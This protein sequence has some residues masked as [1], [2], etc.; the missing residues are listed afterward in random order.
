[1]PDTGTDPH[2]PVGTGELNFTFGYRLLSEFAALGLSHVVISPGSRSTPLTL[3]AAMLQQQG[4]LSAHIILDERSA[5]FFALGIGKSTG[6]PVALICTSGTAAANYFP[7]VIEARMTSTPLLVLSADRPFGLHGVL[8]PQTINQTNLYGDYAVLFRESEALIEADASGLK[9]AELART[10]FE[11]SRTEGGPAHLN[12]GF[13]KPLEPKADR[14]PGLMQWCTETR[15]RLEEELPPLAEIPADEDNDAMLEKLFWL[16]EDADRPLIICGPLGAASVAERRL[17]E[18][19]MSQSRI[20][21]LI[22][23]TASVQQTDTET[24]RS[25]VY[26]YESFLRNKKIVQELKPDFIL[27]VG[28]PPVSRALNDFLKAHAYVVQWCLSSTEQVP[29]P[30]KIHTRFVQFYPF[31][32]LTASSE[33]FAAGLAADDVQQKHDEWR[34]LWQSHESAFGKQLNALNSGSEPNTTL[35]DGQVFRS[36]LGF[37]RE[38]PAH[39]SAAQLFISNSFSVRDL[40]LFNDMPL[41]FA[42]VHHNRGA[43]GIDGIT[44]TA[45]GICTGS[46]TPVWLLLGELSF[47]H[48]TNALLQ[49]S[50]HH[51][52]PLRIIVLNNSGGTIFRML[53]VSAHAGVYE[54]YFETPQQVDLSLLCRAHGISHLKAASRPEFSDALAQAQESAAAVLVIEAVTD[55]TQSMKERRALWQ[56]DNP[57]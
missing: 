40:D 19:T 18:L 30:L 29:D 22:E 43:S 25:T 12:A 32:T 31:S 56:A 42:A 23:G 46:N 37:A 15:Q 9:T 53:P 49:L 10:L 27:R 11:A 26:G 20:P 48:D 7:A 21:H 6:L 24:P 16:L 44:S 34:S 8:A 17:L 45:A 57:R 35:S 2:M 28:F 38:H 36:F 5:A 55:T 4:R 52:A 47:L 3:A 33:S 50:R 39:F 14:I 41:P 51:G 1:M 13:S 54:T